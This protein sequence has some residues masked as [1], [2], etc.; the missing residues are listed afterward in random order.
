MEFEIRKNSDGSYN[1]RDKTY[2]YGGGDPIGG[3]IN[4]VIA[5]I[6]TIIGMIIG[7]ISVIKDAPYATWLMIILDIFVI[8]PTII[9]PVIFSKKIKTHGSYTLSVLKIYFSAFR[10]ILKYAYILFSFTL[11]TY[12]ILF[13]FD[14]GGNFA[15][16]IMFFCMFGIYY[17]PYLM[18]STAKEYG[19]KSLSVVTLIAV[20]IAITASCICAA[21]LGPLGEKYI[22]MYP[23]VLPTVLG[24]FSL[25]SVPV[26]RHRFIK[27]GYGKGAMPLK[28]FFGILAG[29][30]VLVA[31]ILAAL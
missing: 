4:C 11:I 8:A 26:A 31:A 29:A 20:F 30:L 1:V 25:L 24:F 13:Y 14:V 23:V 17:F 5:Y 9:V 18:L 10:Y 15:N 21:V 22:F 2:D 27:Y 12:W 28:V 16:G 3:M 7:T 19:F 6:L